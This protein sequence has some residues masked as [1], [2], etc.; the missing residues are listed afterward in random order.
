MKAVGG[1]DGEDGE[2]GE[3]DSGTVLPCKFLP[4]S[5]FL[6]GGILERI[7]AFHVH[8]ELEA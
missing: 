7:Q 6:L 2:N 4:I 8:R 5:L 3:A 1:G